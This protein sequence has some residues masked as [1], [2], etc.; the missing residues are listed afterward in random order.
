MLS[1]LRESAS[2]FDDSLRS[3][4]RVARGVRSFAVVALVALT[5][6]PLSPACSNSVNGALAFPPFPHWAST[7]PINDSMLAA[8]GSRRTRVAASAA[9]GKAYASADSFSRRDLRFVLQ[10]STIHHKY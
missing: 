9:A 7:S 6:Q 1:F 8:G 5:T 4:R 3:A 10:R 2:G